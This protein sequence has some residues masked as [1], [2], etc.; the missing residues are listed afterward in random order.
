MTT[1]RLSHDPEGRG[2]NSSNFEH[3]PQNQIRTNNTTSTNPKNNRLQDGSSAVISEETTINTEKAKNIAEWAALFHNAR[4][5][6]PKQQEKKTTKHQDRIQP[7][8]MPINGNEEFGNNIDQPTQGNN[9]RIYFQNENGLAVGKGTRKWEDMIQEM[10]T[11]K[12]SVC[13]F[14]ETNFEWNWEKTT[15]RLIAKLRKTAGKATIATSTTNLKFK[16]TYKPGGTATIALHEWSGR[17]M[18]SIR[19]QS[20]QARWSGFQLR[21]KDKT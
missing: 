9:F 5:K 1:T 17:V 2:N 15:A 11:R 13:W 21:T 7:T 8:I 3:L 20:G 4:A 14:A 10:N 12:V 18:E 19:D 6:I 16:S